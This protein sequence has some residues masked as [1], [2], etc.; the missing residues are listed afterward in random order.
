MPKLYVLI[1]V[2]FFSLSIQAQPSNTSVAEKKEEIK[3][4]NAAKSIESKVDDNKSAPAN[5]SKITIPPEKLV[6]V[7]IPKA[8]VSP[9]IDGKVDEVVW[10]QAAVFKDFYQTSPGDNIA[11][12]K[13]T[14]TLMMYD[15]K[16]LYIAFRCW[17]EKDKIRATVAKRDDVFG[18]DNV[19]I[20]LDTYNDQRRAYIL[21]FNP[22]GIQMDGIETEGRG[23]DF[24]VD[25]VMESKGVIEDWGWSVEVKIPFKSLRYTAGKGKMWGFNAARNIDRFN[26]EIDQWM[27]NDRNVSGFLIKHGKITGLDEIKYE[28]TLEITPSITLGET[29]RRLR[30]FPRYRVNEVGYYDPVNNPLGLRETG[31]FVNLPIKQDIGVTLKYTVTPNITLDA[32][33]NP[34]FA[35]I[36]ADAPVVSANQR[37]PIFFE[38]KRPFFLEGADTFQTPL[39]VFYSRQIFDP[40]FAAKLTGKVGK[41]SFGFLAASDNAPGNYDEDD[42]NDR[43]VRP[44]IDEFI[45]KNALFGVLRVKRDFGKEN[46]IGFIATYRGYPEQRNLLGGFDGRYKVN[47]KTV[48]QFQAVATNSRRCFFDAEFEPSLNPLQAQRN[49]EICGGGSFNGVTV[50]GNS[51]QNYRT[52]NGLAYFANYDFTAKN[53]GYYIEVGGRSKDYRADAGFTRRQNTNYAAGGFRLSTETKPKAKIIRVNWFNNFSL[54][55]DWSGRSQNAEWSQNL[56]FTLQKNTYLNFNGGIGYERLFEEEFGLKRMPTRPNGGAFFGDSERSTMNGWLSANLSKQIN[57]KIDIGVFAGTIINA[58]DFDF[59][60]G[61][62]F[63][64]VSP[65]ALAGFSQQDPGTGQQYDFGLGIGWK[66]IN[67]LRIS[68]DYNKSRLV[69]DDTGRVTFDSNI[70]TLRSTYQFTRFIFART[71]LDYDSISSNVRGQL[72]FGWNPSPGT[73]LYAGYNDDLNYNGF[74]PFTGNYEPRFGRNSRTFF[75]RASYLFRKSF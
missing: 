49:R 53:Y 19:R 48:F 27:P 43:S 30:V 62:R 3:S 31:R 51:F 52:G 75:I 32:A 10:Q 57:K 60:G 73:A 22:Y 61:D 42:R 29:G 59:G 65:A 68:L 21:G 4:V 72:L 20:W 37:F 13:P 6:P 39:Q 25:I 47:D 54:N 55:Y 12:S 15:E 44:R 50:E 5:K 41:T 18:E 9:T 28:R 38:E 26:D 1:V 63:P 8:S 69:R 34:D 2:L 16:H 36:E 74:N 46:N 24:S 66:P 58:F 14:E 7:K 11:P 33:Y 17:D 40:D 70:V 64:R 45:D 23:S 35:E 67:P 56:S 71:R